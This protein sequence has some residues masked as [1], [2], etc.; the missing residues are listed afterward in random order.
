[1]TASSLSLSE[2]R[3]KPCFPKSVISEN[4]LPMNIPVEYIFTVYWKNKDGNNGND[5]YMS[6]VYT[7]TYVDQIEP[8][9]EASSNPVDVQKTVTLDASDS[10]FAESKS[11][12]GIM[13]RWKCP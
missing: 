4:G 12:A 7:V 1:M 11:T 2:Q 8:S 10:Q 13:Y 9:L 3:F 5:S 6:V